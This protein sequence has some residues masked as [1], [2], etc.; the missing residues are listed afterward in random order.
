MQSNLDT[1]FFKTIEGE[2]SSARSFALTSTTSSK[3]HPVKTV[4]DGWKNVLN[5]HIFGSSFI[6]SLSEILIWK[7][8]DISSEIECMIEIIPKIEDLIKDA[9]VD[10]GAKNDKVL[11]MS[12]LH[13]SINFLFRKKELQKNKVEFFNLNA[14]PVDDSAENLQQNPTDENIGD[15]NNIITSERWENELAE[16]KSM[17]I[18]EKVSQ[19]EEEET[20]RNNSESLRGD[21]LTEYTHLAIDT[22]AEWD[23]KTLFSSVIDILKYL[24]NKSIK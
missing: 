22:R 12:K 15:E 9:G 1:I 4:F 5:Q 7:A 24:S 2:I 10:L 18:E 14:K 17:L 20:L 3:R 16:W 8:S 6:T 21:L 19:L 13:I 11:L 23:L